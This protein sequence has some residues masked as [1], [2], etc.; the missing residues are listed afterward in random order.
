MG[1]IRTQPVGQSPFV[2]EVAL[3]F[4]TVR[5]GE[6]VLKNQDLRKFEIGIALSQVPGLRSGC[7]NHKV[8][9]GTDWYGTDI[10]LDM[11]IPVNYTGSGGSVIN[12]TDQMST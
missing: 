9:T 7:P 3:H 8:S 4:L 11:Y 2:G 10:V 6:C 1:M 5:G 12:Q